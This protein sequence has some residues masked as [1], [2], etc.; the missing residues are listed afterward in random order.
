MKQGILLVAFGAGTLQSESALHFFGKRVCAYFPDIPV[1][2][3]FT[4][5]ILRER[6][7]QVRKKTDSV[8]K[9]LHKMHF[10]KFT[11]IAVQPLQIIAGKEFSDIAQE[12]LEFECECRASTI[13]L[14][15][16]L[17]ASDDDVRHT[18]KAIVHHLPSARSP[19]EHVVLMGHGA[20][21][22]AVQRYTE[23]AHAVYVLDKRVHVGAMY[24]AV[25]LDAILPQLAKGHRVWLMPLM[26]VVG[27]HTL[28]DMAGHD[29]T[30]WRS[31]I[32]AQ[33]CLCTPI[34]KGMV[35]Y[36]GFIDIWLNHLAIAFNAL[37]DV[38]VSAS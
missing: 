22:T 29:P 20:N 34:L 14:G 3:A 31:R 33:G 32:E 24:G 21:H 15:T 13:T 11:H 12:V 36:S 19:Q 28:K 18:A 10:E 37:E 17:L 7:A 27:G 5:P 8:R 1:R 6:L 26:S 30:S 4:S 2:W 9:S 38:C 16:P 35:E 25:T 23:L